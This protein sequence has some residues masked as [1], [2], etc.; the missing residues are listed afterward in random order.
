MYTLSADLGNP[1]AMNNI[2]YYHQHI[3]KDYVKMKKYYM[4]AIEKKFKP[5]ALNLGNYYLLIENNEQEK[6]RLYAL[7]DTM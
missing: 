5:S 6:K 4:L 3:D 7:A 1:I 2:G